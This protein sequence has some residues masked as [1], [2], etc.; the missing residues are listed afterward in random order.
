[1]P[2]SAFFS[3]EEIIA[4][5][6]QIVREKGEDALSARS[7][8]KALNC[9]ISPI[10]TVFKNMEEVNESTR[11]AG[12]KLFSSYV[13][14]ISDYEPAFKE[15]GLRLI[16]FAREENNLFHFIFLHSKSASE[17]M[18]PKALYGLQRVCDEFSITEAQ[19]MLLLRQIW[20]FAC[21]LAVLCT[22]DESYT[23][24]LVSEMLSVQ[25]MSTVSFI[26]SGN[27]AANIIPHKKQ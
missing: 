23:D 12:K 6:L 27:S 11:E 9:S 8:S 18:H 17:R 13:E 1:M 21:G 4:A 10:F 19:A 5:A 24:E 25:F 20:T 7:L 26:R 15:F 16:R 2:R 22:E 14:D 3:K